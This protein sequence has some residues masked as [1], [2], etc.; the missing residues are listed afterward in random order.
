[1]P[2]G[3]LRV[4]SGCGNIP[5]VLVL[6]MCSAAMFSQVGRFCQAAGVSARL[7]RITMARARRFWICDPLRRRLALS[8]L[9]HCFACLCVHVHRK[10][11]RCV[12]TWL[13]RARTRV[14]K[15]LRSI[16]LL[17][18]LWMVL[19]LAL[20]LPHMLAS[21]PSRKTSPT[22]VRGAFRVEFTWHCVF[23]G[24]HRRSQRMGGF[25]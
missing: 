9:A 2:S 21:A 24:R 5:C 4:P 15:T 8:L 16:A 14:P 7:L 12:A 25:L 13:S 6:A 18:G 3:L 11:C 1:M 20:R 10:K 22:L 19:A 17:A 23:S